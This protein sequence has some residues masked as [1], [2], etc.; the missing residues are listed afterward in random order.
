MALPFGIKKSP[1]ILSPNKKV[2][3]AQEYLTF[4]E[5][6]ELINSARKEAEHII[7]E[8]HKT[9]EALRERGYQEGLLEGKQKIAEKMFETVQKTVDYLAS[10]EEMLCDIVIDAVRRVIGEFNDRELVIRIVRNAMAVVR[11]QKHVAIKVSPQDVE[12]VKA[13]VD[14]LM[15]Q[16][17]AVE[18]IEVVPDVRLS[19][20]SCILESEMGIV[21]ASVEVQLKALRNALMKTVRKMT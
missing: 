11:S 14:G 17:P 5:A 7:S 1:V 10:S 9:V 12:V 15:L 16:F 21:D 19:P 18:F 4:V 13:E 2:L 8:A 6:S 3:K 20:K